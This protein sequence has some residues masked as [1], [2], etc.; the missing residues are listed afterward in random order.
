MKKTAKLLRHLAN[1]DLH[2][3]GKNEIYG[4]G[5][6]NTPVSGDNG[7]TVDCRC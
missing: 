6:G 2:S 1:A 4:T 3:G 5:P 7:E